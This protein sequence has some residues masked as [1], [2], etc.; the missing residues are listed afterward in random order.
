MTNNPDPSNP[1]A[2]AL[3][4]LATVTKVISFYPAQHPTVVSSL[5]KATLFL[6]E[7]LT[8]RQSLTISVAETAFLVDGSVLQ[9]EDHVL[10]GFA[11]VVSRLPEISLNPSL[12]PKA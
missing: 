1:L 8:D 9:A 2:R 10:G 3:K 7:A 4:Q 6:K 11:S 5:E 12:V